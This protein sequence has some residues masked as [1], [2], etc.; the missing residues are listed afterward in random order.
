MVT[1]NSIR[2]NLLVLGQLQALDLST[3]S[4]AIFRENQNSQT[5]RETILRTLT[6]SSFYSCTQ[7]QIC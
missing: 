2:L 1:V 4:K 3:N 7:S 6:V 5:S